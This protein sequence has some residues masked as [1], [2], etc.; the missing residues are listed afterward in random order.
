MAGL[1]EAP[2]AMTNAVAFT[3]GDNNLVI[4]AQDT[5]LSANIWHNGV[6]K[7]VGAGIALSTEVIV[8]KQSP[9]RYILT[10]APDFMIYIDV[11]EGYVNM[12]VK[13]KSAVCRTASGI[14]GNCDADPTNDFQTADGDILTVND[15]QY[16]LTTEYINTGFIQ[17]WETS[18]TVFTDVIQGISA[19]PGSMCLLIQNSQMQS[20]P[21]F[22]FTEKEI[23][24]EIKFKI[25][26][27]DV[28]A[29]LWSYTNEDKKTFSALVC[30]GSLVFATYSP[31]EQLTDMDLSVD[32]NKWY[33][34]S[35]VWKD[36]IL[37]F[38]LIGQYKDSISANTKADNVVKVF[39]NGGT[40]QLGMT[41][42]YMYPYYG[43]IDDFAVWKSAFTENEI[44]SRAFVY[45]VT[46]GQT[47]LSNIWRFNRGHGNTVYD[48][49]GRASFTWDMT[50][51]D[52]SW[53]LCSYEM[54]Y[55]AYDNSKDMLILNPP[56]ENLLICAN[57]I[58]H[59][60]DHVLN[61][62][63]IDTYNKECLLELAVAV[64]NTESV[65]ADVLASISDNLEPNR[66]AID[67]PMRKLCN[68]IQPSNWYGP[69]CEFYCVYMAGEFNV[70]EDQCNCN[71]GYYGKSCESQCPYSRDEVCGGGSCDAVDGKCT[72]SSERFD[73]ATD[74]ETCSQGWVG[75]DCASTSAN[76]I[77]S[78]SVRFGG[79]FGNGHFLMFDGQAYSMK[80]PGQYLLFR[81]TDT[82]VYVR[83]R[84]CGGCRTCIQQV[85][86]HMN[87]GE[88]T[89]KVPLMKNKPI[90]LQH[91]DESINIPSLDTIDI[92]SVATIGWID[93][94][95]LRFVLDKL[96]VDV[97]YT[98]T[99][100][101]L[102]VFVKTDCSSGGIT[103]L[104]GNCNLN[105]D[106][107]FIYKD[108]TT[109]DY[110]E[111][112][113]SFIDEEFASAFIVD[114]PTKFIYTYPDIHI[115]EPEDMTQGY[116]LLFNGS[117]AIS[118]TVLSS[119]S[120][121]DELFNLTI[122]VKMQFLVQ[123]GAGLI[124]GY[125]KY[126][127]ENEFGLYLNESRLEVYMNEAS[128]RT[129]VN[130]ETD[131][132]YH[133]LVTLDVLNEDMDIYV[134][135]NG[136]SVLHDH[137]ATTRVSLPSSG[138]LFLGIWPMDLPMQFDAF[139]GVI[140]A[141]KIWDIHLD[142]K[143]IY[144]LVNDADIDDIE[145]LA[146]NFQFT[147]GLGYATFDSRQNV[148][149]AINKDD[150]VAWIIS[151]KSGP[152]TDTYA[153][154]SL[155][156]SNRITLC[157]TMF[158][159][160]SVT[161]ACDGLGIYFST[162]YINACKLDDSYIPALNAFITTCKDITVTTSN[163]VTDL[164]NETS[165]H[166]DSLCGEF[167]MQGTF[168]KYGCECYLGFWDWNCAKSCSNRVPITNEPCFGHGSCD[169]DKGTCICRTNYDSDVNC[170]TC[171][172]PITGENCD[173]AEITLPEMPRA[174][175]SPVQSLCQIFG[176]LTV[177]TF[178]GSLFHVASAREW[179]LLKSTGDDYPEI[180]V[181]TMICGMKIC[182]CSLQL[183]YKSEII[184]ID[185]TI[186]DASRRIKVNGKYN[187][188]LLENFS[189]IKKSEDTIVLKRIKTNMDHFLKVTISFRD[190]GYMT[191][192]IKSDCINCSD[193]ESLCL[194][195][196]SFL[197]TYQYGSLDSYVHLLVNES[198]Q[199]LSDNIIEP[200]NEAQYSIHFGADTS[201]TDPSSGSATGD[202]FTKIST[203][204]L[205]DVFSPSKSNT[206]EFSIIPNV[207]ST[208]SIIE[209]VAVTTFMVF[210]KNGTLIVQAGDE[211]SNTGIQL[212][213]DLTSNVKIY[214]DD[215]SQ[216]MT[217][218][219]V[220]EDADSDSGWNEP[221]VHDISV[222]PECFSSNGILLI[223]NPTGVE[224]DGSFIGQLDNLK[225]F[226]DEKLELYFNFDK[227]PML[228]DSNSY[229]VIE[230]ISGNERHM[231]I[232]DPYGKGTLYFDISSIP[233]E[234]FEVQVNSG[235]SNEEDYSAAIETCTNQFNN[236]NIQQ[237]CSE[238]G[239]NI[240][241]IYQSSCI[242][243]IASKGIVN[244]DDLQAYTTY[245][246]DWL[247]DDESDMSTQSDPSQYLCVYSVSQ[248]AF[249]GK[250]CDIP[251]FKPEAYD[252]VVPDSCI[253]DTG[254]YGPTC[255]SE[256]PGGSNNPCTGH[257]SCSKHNGTCTCSMNFQGDDCSTCKP[258]WYGTDCQ[259]YIQETAANSD[260]HTA[261]IAANGFI[262]TIDG[263][264]TQFYN[265]DQ[266]CLLFENSAVSI[267]AQM[268]PNSLYQSGPKAFAITIGN[269]VVTINAQGKVDV[270]G[271]YVDLESL[272]L[273]D[274]YEITWQSATEL[275][276]K[277]PDNLELV[278]T[279]GEEDSLQASMS[280]NKAGCNEGS[281][282]FGK[283]STG[284]AS[285]CNEADITCLIEQLGL[286]E[287]MMTY[288]INIAQ[289][290][291]YYMQISIDYDN[292]AFAL[293]EEIQVTAGSS[294]KLSQGAYI[295]LPPV[296]EYVLINNS[297]SQSI[298]FRMKLE[299]TTTGTL[300]SAANSQ[301]TFGVVLK[302]GMYVIQ[303]GEYT[304]STGIV[305]TT[306]VWT[307]IAI[308]FD[309]TT[310][311]LFFHEINVG[312]F[313]HYITIDM[314]DSIEKY[315]VP[316]TIGGNMA[317][318]TW[319]NMNT[320]Y[321]TVGPGDSTNTPI[322]QI[323]RFIF[324]QNRYTINEI[325]A[326]FFMNINSGDYVPYT[327]TDFDLLQGK[328]TSSDISTWPGDLPDLAVNFDEA[329]GAKIN[330][331]VQGTYGSISF[332]GTY[333]WMTSDPPID[334][335]SIPEQNM[336][337]ITV[338]P[339]IDTSVCD[340]MQQILNE[341]CPSLGS[342]DNFFYI[343]CISMVQSTGNT[344]NSID[345]ITLANQE[346]IKQEGLTESPF[347]SLCNA[348]GSREFPTVVGDNCE[349]ICQFGTFDID[350][351]V[352]DEFH[353]GLSCE[354]RCEGGD[355]PCS[356]HGTCDDKTG[357]CI[358]LRKW[359]GDLMCSKCYEDYMG[360][361]CEILITDGDRTDLET[362]DG[363]DSSGGRDSYN[364]SIPDDVYNGT[365]MRCVMVGMHGKII[366]FN[367]LAK[368]QPVQ[369]DKTVLLEI[370]NLRIL[371]R[372]IIN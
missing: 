365:C 326:H 1:D 42:G 15:P 154:S 52:I 44:E 305:A 369:Y 239:D 31:E 307:N 121:I 308:G 150:Q 118:G 6:S 333:E 68:K 59:L 298:E 347:S 181:Q 220:S 248:S 286:A 114:T 45:T 177:F 342:Q 83:M 98:K 320:A 357:E 210:I 47:E 343:S 251:C 325:E 170:D 348:F 352:C 258:Y 209:Y 139:I 82:S 345:T 141:V 57:T 366:M 223:G 282:L 340:S 130:L 19:E 362:G 152:T 132:W 134:F 266:P 33:K 138:Q 200:D 190:K 361:D 273:L 171:V 85:W 40:F 268:G 151:D 62:A 316:F 5:G 96:T 261:Y 50:W 144:T 17:S 103:G 328:Y 244:S 280:V 147:E 16:P 317:L 157:E 10:A 315:G 137:F 299:T 25:V 191:V 38:Y 238:L 291:Q 194:Q 161:T 281:G 69:T 126:Q 131:Q 368:H 249:V 111:I 297:T 226:S 35:I 148:G 267:E 104:L 2:V 71:Y 264:S 173:R 49:T 372:T 311:N 185:G 95:T 160:D 12:V 112:S 287:V 232:F 322:F 145:G 202:K 216:I 356:N 61:D 167:C 245:C 153:C 29:T 106:D 51:Q 272:E 253:C 335:E 174:D 205:I 265:K 193:I 222:S 250:D 302:N 155:S 109:K 324:S 312:D 66:S 349:S 323:D 215:L 257:G 110:S 321:K 262:K 108:G 84:P 339:E 329:S 219:V 176:S 27:L 319:Q 309:E 164:C 350:E 353:Y 169:K 28:C 358:C 94:V 91:N 259:V 235:F 283:C 41:P 48:S 276:I 331:L 330:D 67:Y 294:V 88:F 363:V 39:S 332:D 313:G 55:P 289:L 63:T 236:I 80:R 303:Y 26:K 360:E 162:F 101:Y 188:T 46:A 172:S 168:T 125:S 310:G 86:F 197:E 133:I 159:I 165:D 143:K 136:S 105:K 127:S 290:H 23:T 240:K 254:Y 129:S 334:M 53:A 87:D 203:K 79:S 217:I 119:S 314:Q 218:S 230:D 288:N 58:S 113:S 252:D 338:D 142:K 54:S 115:V 166:F 337:G 234:T 175:D 140:G 22:Y 256:C 359:S 295:V 221:S 195:N 229:S 100:P 201:V 255:A 327:S 346:C 89:V 21:V 20:T 344:D 158:Q 34:L 18:T 117:G 206:I 269:K 260:V 90:L 97:S 92:T 32:F 8:T 341:Y 122:E 367:E 99:S 225:V 231:I 237:T 163:P 64:D 196:S 65:G 300:F 351:C 75:K 24:I 93:K 270:N 156:D 74:C 77:T 11:R 296:N 9:T 224:I 364:G 212:P 199:I 60:E 70:E 198:N 183:S 241:A 263:A 336:I 370:N 184:T 279:V 243:H 304:Y 192:T 228:H 135:S 30:S 371:V 36:E 128:F 149:M 278:F 182:L 354:E 285:D 204:P 124:L 247:T 242:D 116:N 72:C 180:T 207:G 43:Y 178:D 187:A 4:Q 275:V 120:S 81:N 284:S 318:G 233:A 102:S 292:T 56:G 189:Y 293:A 208:G 355:Y 3:I 213:A 37:N 214:Y 107:D 123:M 76:I 301:S 186:Q 227:E 211:I 306:N 7:D 179:Y 274:G 78:L 277:G 13:A 146:V 246:N 73:P 271:K 14:L